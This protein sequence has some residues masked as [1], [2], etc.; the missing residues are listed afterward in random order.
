MTTELWKP[1]PGSSNCYVSSLGRVRRDD[2]EV[3]P[4]LNPRTGYLQV[5]VRYPDRHRTKPIHRLV[6]EAFLGPRPSHL[7]TRH[8]NGDPHDN[9]IINLTYGTHAENM[10]DQVRH[11]THRMASAEACGN[12]HPYTPENTRHRGSHRICRECT[13]LASTKS[14]AKVRAAKITARLAAGLPAD[15]RSLKSKRPLAELAS[16]C[17]WGHPFSGENVR[18]VN[19]DPRR[20]VCRT[21][22]AAAAARYRARRRGVLAPLAVAA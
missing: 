9:R 3:R 2:V 12:G 11:G 15:L 21:C 13:R 14:N 18:F 20:R 6:G 4:M 1:I 17:K 22:E 19:G 7:E 8:L 10:R 5:N 16:H